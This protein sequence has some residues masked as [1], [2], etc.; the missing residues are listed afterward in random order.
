MN[1]TQELK[2]GDFEPEHKGQ[3]DLYLKWLAKYEQQ[4]DEQS[5]I[6]IILCGGKDA[7]LYIASYIIA[8]LFL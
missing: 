7:E 8:V 5:P 3:V 6:A 4:P 1:T 2:L